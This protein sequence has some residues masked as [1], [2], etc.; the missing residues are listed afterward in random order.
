MIFFFWN[1]FIELNLQG[2]TTN[3]TFIYEL[4]NP[5]CPANCDTGLVIITLQQVVA[6]DI[7]NIFTPNGDG[8]NDK[9]FVRGNNIKELYFAVYD[10]WGEKVFETTDKNYG[11]DGSY[12]GNNLNGN[13]FVYYCY[14]KY[15]DGLEFKQKG[16]VTLV[17]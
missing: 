15:N 10:R 17:R 16:D 9:L 13:V 5:V 3:Q 7:P 6:C 1:T 11:W 12:K 8:N 2:V 14:G 4:C